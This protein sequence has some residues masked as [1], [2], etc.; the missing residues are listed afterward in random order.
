VAVNPTDP[1]NVVV[2]YHQAVGDGSDHHES[3]IVE[4]HVAWSVDGGATWV[5]AEAS[6]P[7]Y[8]MSIDASVAFDPWGQAYLLFLSMDELGLATRNGEFICR[9]LDGGRTWGPPTALV[10]RTAAGGPMLNHLA[11][12]AIDPISGRLYVTWDRIYGGGRG[13]LCLVRSFDGGESW[14]SPR[15]ISP[16]GARQSMAVGR[17]GS[18]YVMH[19]FHAR[20]GV[21]VEL[22][23][24]RDRGDVFDHPRAVLRTDHLPFDPNAPLWTDPSWA[25][26]T[27]FGPAA[28]FPRAC[29]TPVMAAD[30][31]SVP[32]RL[33]VA[34][35]D[36]RHGDRDVFV[37]A[38]GDEGR[39]WTP[40]TR[41]N[42]DARDNGRDQAMQAIAVDES[43]GAVYVLFYDRR[44]DARNLLPTV[45]LARSVDGARSFANYTFGTPPTD[46][47]AA[48]LGDYISVAARG[49]VVYAAWP[50][51]LPPG[52]EAS[53]DD[54]MAR[55]NPALEGLSWPSGPAVIRIGRAVFN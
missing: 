37:T 5:R 13:D 42:D 34:W 43:D 9:S 20:G 49:G 21:E 28:D 40:A 16:R 12:L 51:S 18:L 35:G 32:A 45:T 14:S 44:N 27:S 36:Y 50:E 26:I 33:Y 25:Q 3:V 23:I 7:D 39:T 38:S 2:S 8:R 4:T 24:S 17:D 30:V 46:P 19:A 31:R 10:E 6:H 1:E 53:R 48:C 54:V 55:L 15:M 11:V 22:A 47:N 52:E 41:V 29:G